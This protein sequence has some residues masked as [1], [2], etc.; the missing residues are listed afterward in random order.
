MK[1]LVVRN[2]K[3]GDFVLALPAFKAIKQAFPQAKVVA[4]VPAYTLEIANACEWIDEAIV[5][6][7]KPEQIKSF[8]KLLQTQQFDAAICLFS[9]SYNAKLVRKARIP[10]RVAPAT[11]WVQLLYTHTLKQRRSK[12]EKP[13]FQYNLE[14]AYYLIEVLKGQVQTTSPHQLLAFT[15]EQKAAQKE[16]LTEALGV[17]FA[18]RTC[19]IHP[20]TGGS[21]NTLSQAQWCKLIAFLDQLTPTHFVITAGPG[22]SAVSK[23]LVDAMTGQVE[24]ISLYDKNDGV[25][26]FMRS[27]SVADLFIAGSTG[28]LHIAGAL[29]VPTI[30]FYPKKRSS[31]PL[32]WQTLNSA[33]RWLPFTP[34]E[35]Q[36]DL[37]QFEVEPHLADIQAWCETLGK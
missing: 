25:E 27:I 6:P 20:V 17:S 3:I 9:N 1:I 2:D 15:N 34:S 23:A 31:T 29:D 7:Q 30:G 14:L 22:E 11:K 24:R 36:E 5:D 21:S 12:S 8:A 33:G 18:E 13:E 4:L 37:S 32:R 10:V 28:P 26:D 16:K 19:F 35:Q